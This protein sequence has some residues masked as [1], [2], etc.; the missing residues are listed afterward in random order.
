MPT[1]WYNIRKSD[2]RMNKSLGKFSSYSITQ[3]SREGSAGIMRFLQHAVIPRK[4]I[5]NLLYERKTVLCFRCWVQSLICSG[6]FSDR[7]TP[8]LPDHRL[9]RF[10]KMISPKRQNSP[11]KFSPEW[12]LFFNIQSYIFSLLIFLNLSVLCGWGRLLKCWN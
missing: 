8:M 1:G 11:G 12:D 7:E 4:T 6:F 2:S 9:G 3:E 10:R 5:W